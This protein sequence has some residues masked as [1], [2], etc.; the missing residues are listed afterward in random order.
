MS[1]RLEFVSYDG[2]YPC[3]CYGKLKLKIDGRIITFPDGS[4][5]SGGSAGIG[6]DGDEYCT[7]GKWKIV[8]FPKDFPDELKEEACDVVNKN[9][10]YGC[11]GGCI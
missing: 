6:G 10:P 11:C 3:L 8:K 5:S 1:K 7:S 2:S 9:V 4:L